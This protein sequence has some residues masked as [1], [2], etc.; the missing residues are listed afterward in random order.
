MNLTGHN[1]TLL[2]SLSTLLDEKNV[3]RAAARLGLTQ[4]ALSAQLARLRD[5][6]G[7]ALLI[8]ATSGKGMVLTARAEHLREPLR[9]A[10]QVVEDVVTHLPRFDPAAS[11]RIFVIGANDNASAI[12]G[13]R[14]VELLQVAGPLGIRLSIRAIDPMRLT[15]Q[16]ESGEIDVALV[17]H[18]AV[19]GMSHELLLEEDFRMAQ[20]RDH[21]RGITPPTME[22]YVR[23]EHVIVSGDG[24]GFHG[25]IDDLLAEKGFARRVVVA[26]QYYNVVPL[27]LHTTDMV[28][29]LPARFLDRYEGSLVSLP[30]P[31]EVRRF[32][33]FAAWHAR[34]DKDLAHA[35]LR[36]QLAI[37]TA[38]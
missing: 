35:W 33:L 20:R 1:L 29:T 28:C 14:L 22:E 4:P 12:V 27:L 25:F 18:S 26:V 2:V 19:G 34:F 38:A 24:R 3:T 6:F 9:Q 8:P 15:E 31:F 11:D 17:T 7:D 10:L 13:P 5:L 21:K 30:L 37:C 23:L 16:L 32:S 36:Q